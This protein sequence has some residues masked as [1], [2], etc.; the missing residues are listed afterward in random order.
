MIELRSAPKWRDGTLP[1]A[2]DPT[3]T[4]RHVR[5]LMLDVGITHMVEL[6]SFDILGVPIYA[7]FGPLGSDDDLRRYAH[8]ALAN[9][10]ERVEQIL[11]KLEVLHPA[12]TI[13]K[14]P[15]LFTA[16]KGLSLLDSQLSAMMEAIERFSA[17]YPT[18]TPVVGSYNEMQR[19]GDLEVV[20]PRKLTLLSPSTYNYDLKLE[21]VLGTDLFVGKEVWLPAD[22]ATLSY[23]PRKVDRV[24]S[25]TPTGLGAGNSVEEAVCHGLAEA[26][27]HDAWTLAIA[28][29]SIKSA[30]RG[31][32]EVLFGNSD[33]AIVEADSPDDDPFPSLDLNSLDGVEHV[34]AKFSRIRKTGVQVGAQDITSDIGIPTFSVSI[35][36]L[37]GGPEGGGLGAHPDARLA[38]SRALTEA[39][40]QRLVLG[41]GGESSRISSTTGWRWAPWEN[42]RIDIERQG[43]RRFEEVL[44]QMHVDILEDIQHMMKALATRGLEQVIAVDLTK[45]E[46]GVPVVKVIVP[47]LA[48]YWTSESPPQWE[49]L[50]QRVMRYLK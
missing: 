50:G 42:R 34:A 1:R 46:I 10:E 11:T 27:E 5:P 43:V 3:D 19:R 12:S 40:Q 44:S 32:Q 23:K 35:S 4:H 48:D 31:I 13:P 15:F 9:D 29:S 38:L 20:D 37:P 41:L 6:T 28:R 49:A 22:A 33:E 25:D 26:I 17:S 8:Q 2:V 14:K 39:A 16:G 18:V 36:A 24:C 21:W 7:A 30:Q 45:A 47:G